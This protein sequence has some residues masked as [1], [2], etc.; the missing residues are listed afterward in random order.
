MTVSTCP[1]VAAFV[2]TALAVAGLS[3]VRGDDIT[4]HNAD[5]VDEG[6]SRGGWP[7]YGPPGPTPPTTPRLPNTLSACAGG[8]AVAAD[9]QLDFGSGVLDIALQYMAACP[10]LCYP[11]SPLHVPR[12]PRTP[13]CCRPP[14]V[15]TCPT[16]PGLLSP[17]PSSP[18]LHV[19][20]VRY[21]HWAPSFVPPLR[22]F[23]PSWHV[24]DGLV[25]SGA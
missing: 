17:T 11:L 18:Q 14:F 21:R 19:L 24:L 8:V 1:C 10:S 6:G 9:D 15:L 20:F 2:P 22:G 5:R 25:Q 23:P 16:V 12:L 3:G 7:A 4:M 13:F